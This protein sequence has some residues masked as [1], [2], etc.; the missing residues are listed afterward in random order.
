MMQVVGVVGG[1]CMKMDVVLRYRC[2][3]TSIKD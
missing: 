1:P 3:L 2:R